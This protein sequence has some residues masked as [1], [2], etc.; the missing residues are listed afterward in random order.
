M[1][2]LETISIRRMTTSDADLFVEFYA[3]LSEESLYFFTAHDPNPSMLRELI[4]GIANEPNVR[5]FAA[6]RLVDGKEEMAGYVFL[7]T[8]D[9]TVPWLG[10]CV[11]DSYKGMGVGNLLMRHAETF[12]KGHGKGGILLTTHQKNYKAQNLYKKVGYE[13]IGFDDRGE[14]LMILRLK[15]LNWRAE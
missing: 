8:L 1:V 14:I 2:E 10:I 5:R 11:R 6:V 12:C 3:A 9:T 15:D 7:W 13:Q 4:A